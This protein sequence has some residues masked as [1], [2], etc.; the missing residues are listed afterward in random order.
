MLAAFCKTTGLVLSG[1]VNE[2][3]TKAFGGKLLGLMVRHIRG[4]LLTG[5]LQTAVCV[6]AY[7][8]RLVQSGVFPESQHSMGKAMYVAP[9][10]PLLHVHL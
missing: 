8:A 5:E 10:P 1:E 4:K 2:E 6:V 3:E 9:C 7:H